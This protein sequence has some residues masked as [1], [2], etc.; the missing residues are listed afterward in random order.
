MTNSGSPTSSTTSSYARQNDQ[1][2][3]D[4]DTNDIQER[5]SLHDNNSDEDF[6]DE[7]SDFKESDEI[8]GDDDFGD[9]DDGFQSPTDEDASAGEQPPPA[10]AS[11]VSSLI[12]K[13]PSHAI[14][15]AL[16]N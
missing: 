3:N 6:G 4:D 2:T 11:F 15:H 8:A 14:F 13:V 5:E 7:F 10:P 1:L 12:V 16:L 9:F